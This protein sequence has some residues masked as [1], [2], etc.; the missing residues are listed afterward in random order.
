MTDPSVTAENSADQLL[1]AI[2]L[3]S[4]SFHM[5]VAQLSQGELRTV[6]VMSD[7]VQLAAGIN[8][9]RYLTDE[10]K[11]R[12][13]ECLSRFAQRVKDLPRDSVRVVGTKR[14]ARHETAVNLLKKPKPFSTHRSRSS[15]DARKP[16]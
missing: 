8:A 13:L 14:C 5:V 10:A 9:K 15:P 12:G 4:N 16:V 7:K 11:Q 6:D 3:G 2:D 1:A